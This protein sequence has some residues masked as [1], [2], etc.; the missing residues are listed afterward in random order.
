MTKRT[1]AQGGIRT[2]DR[3]RLAGTE[4]TGTVHEFHYGLAAVAWDNHPRRSKSFE[5][6]GM[7]ERIEPQ[8]K[9]SDAQEAKT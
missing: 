4:I 6:P 7:L 8:T 9:C 3:V 5:E 2:E 1:T